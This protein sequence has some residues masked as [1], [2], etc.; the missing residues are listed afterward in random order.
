MMTHLAAF[1]LSVVLPIV[2]L[3][4]VDI[5][6]E[7]HHAESRNAFVIKMNVIVQIVMAP[8]HFK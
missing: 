4:N 1:M 8:T 2:I 6:A 7:S 3:L 5:S